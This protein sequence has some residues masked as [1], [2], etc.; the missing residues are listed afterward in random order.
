MQT[1]PKTEARGL[2]I[3]GNSKY[4]RL[5]QVSMMKRHRCVTRFIATPRRRQG[6]LSVSDS[7]ASPAIPRRPFLT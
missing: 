2:A 4:V 7:Y 3:N 1:R 6:L 5:G